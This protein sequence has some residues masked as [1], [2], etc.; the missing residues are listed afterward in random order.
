MKVGG[1]LDSDFRSS[2]VYSEND[3]RSYLNSKLNAKG[4]TIQKIEMYKS[5]FIATVELV[6]PVTPLEP[7][8]IND[9]KNPFKK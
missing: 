9:G 1:T 4:F 3:V 8:A 6:K 7:I 5:R 2:V